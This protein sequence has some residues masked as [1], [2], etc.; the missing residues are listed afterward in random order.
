MQDAG[1][2]LKGEGMEVWEAGWEVWGVVG[3]L[4]GRKEKR[5]H[6]MQSNIAFGLLS[7]TGQFIY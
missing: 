4:G 5:E 6:L 3:E 2:C 1:V 7:S